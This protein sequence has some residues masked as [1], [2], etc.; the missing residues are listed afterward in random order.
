MEESLQIFPALKRSEITLFQKFFFGQTPTSESLIL[1]C[2]RSGGLG[3][4]VKKKSGV[5]VFLVMEEAVRGVQQ[6][7]GNLDR[8]GCV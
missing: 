2:R 8:G 7:V 5:V 1:I 4:G 3:S 6:T